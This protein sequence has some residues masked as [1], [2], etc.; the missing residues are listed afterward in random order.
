MYSALGTIETKYLR[1]D[2]W[3][4]TW[5]W[6]RDFSWKDVSHT[7]SWAKGKQELS[8]FLFFCQISQKSS[9]ALSPF[10]LQ[11]ILGI[12]EGHWQIWE[13]TEN[14][15]SGAGFYHQIWLLGWN[16][17][18]LGSS[19]GRL[20]SL[21]GRSS[22]QSLARGMVAPLWPTAYLQITRNHPGIRWSINKSLEQWNA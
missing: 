3:A 10:T 19:A 4:K 18:C 12:W 21:A 20:L 6:K 8:S 7:V 17:L 9:P 15:Q 1:C 14:R 16:G 22:G 2:W 13:V 5:A 11:E